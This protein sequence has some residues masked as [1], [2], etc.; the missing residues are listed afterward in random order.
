MIKILFL[1]FCLVSSNLS[2]SCIIKDNS[3]SKIPEK[4]FKNVQ[5]KKENF[6]NIVLKSINDVYMELNCEHKKLKDLI[7][8]GKDDTIYY[9]KL[10]NK[11]RAKNN[12]ELL[13]KI[14]PHPVSIALA[15]AA[16]ESSW[17]TSR[18]SLQ[19][20]NLFGIWSFNS[21][22]P[23]IAANKKRGSK[24]IYLKKYKTVKDS[25]YDYYLNLSRNNNY[26]KFN[27]LKNNNNDPYII[28]KGLDKYSEKGSDYGV[29]LSSI[30]RYNK[31]YL[32]DKK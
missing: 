27:I 28:V 25:V 18:F 7:D 2:F 11:Y 8:K 17:G 10:R 3:L 15:Q 20:N 16:L 30:I 24:T 21:S 31:F 6:K 4:T 13:H 32:Y 14:K 19:A 5:E 26:K 23:R 9:S 12:T 29:L 1:F 22:E